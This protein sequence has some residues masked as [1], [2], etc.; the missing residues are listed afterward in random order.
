MFFLF[1]LLSSNNFFFAYINIEG[2]SLILYVLASC[3]NNN[4]VSKESSFKYL[5]LSSVASG[6]LLMGII[7]FYIVVNSLNFNA[8]N[9]Y[10]LKLTF[11]NN[12]ELHIQFAV[13]LIFIAF[14]FKIGAF[15]CYY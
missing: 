2:L 1:A 14:L 8:L 10:L 12:F 11:N 15:P 7:W 6:L 9:Y 13:I 4:F 5:A 3:V